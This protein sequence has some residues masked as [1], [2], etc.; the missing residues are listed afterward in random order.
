LDGLANEVEGIYGGME[1]LFTIVEVEMCIKFSWEIVN[2][3]F[4]FCWFY[5][6]REYWV[7]FSCLLFILAH[8]QPNIFHSMY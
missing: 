2:N 7:I 4:I 8:N 6:S 3:F 5:Q 1:L